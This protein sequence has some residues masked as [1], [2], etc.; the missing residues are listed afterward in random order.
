LRAAL[1]AADRAAASGADRT[2]EVERASAADVARITA[3]L[4]DYDAALAE[5]AAAARAD[6]SARAEF[7]TAANQSTLVHRLAGSAARAAT[8][9]EASLASL[10]RAIAQG[11]T[12][13]ATTNALLDTNP[14]ANLLY[15]LGALDRL[16]SLTENI[17]TV[18]A[19]VVAERNR[20]N[21]LAEQDEQLSADVDR[22][23]GRV[24][25][26]AARSADADT[27]V[28]ASRGRLLALGS[29]L[30][31]NALVFS[32][33]GVALASVLAPAAGGLPSDH[34]WAL[35]AIG[36]VTSG[37]GPRPDLPVPGVGGVHYGTD[38]GAPCGAGVY[39]ATSGIVA[40]VG[41]VGSYGN[42][43]LIDH[44]EGV[45]T[46][47]AHVAT[48]STRVAVGDQVVAGQI[49]A[50][51]GSTGLST[52]CHLHFEVRLEGIRVDAV[53][54][55]ESRGIRFPGLPFTS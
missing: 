32:S 8:T 28:A 36:R 3:A 26:A 48:G 34:G 5:V 20:A 22:G 1:V 9:S 12:M 46:G 38:L 13:T 54:F 6:S 47:Y 15:R 40:A 2:A 39:A 16:G 29:T 10:V 52:G 45:A 14:D 35:P 17:A 51:V 33:A 24:T 53:P 25:Q 4:A 37:Y 23:R 43:I 55:L 19:R 50:L 27:A 42:W 49:I 18:S 7:D 11:E 44:G 41:A 21:D 30:S 31:M